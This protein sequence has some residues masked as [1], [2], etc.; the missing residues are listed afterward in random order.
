MTQEDIQNQ[1]ES[2]PV[3]TEDGAEILVP[4]TD[5]YPR[6]SRNRLQITTTPET[7]A[8]SKRVLNDGERSAAFEFG[9]RFVL[10]LKGA[11]STEEIT[12]EIYSAIGDDAF[13]KLENI[14]SQIVEE[15][16]YNF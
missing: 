14:Q 6:G 1:L 5:L 13:L 10:Y 7:I 9:L 3:P 16:G 2:L 12:R 15:H 8:I 11:I 4:L